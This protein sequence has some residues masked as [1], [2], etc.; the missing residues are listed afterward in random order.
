MSLSLLRRKLNPEYAPKIA[1]LEPDSAVFRIQIVDSRLNVGGQNVP[2]ASQAERLEQN[3]LDIARSLV[4][5]SHD[6]WRANR[7]TGN[8][9]LQDGTD[10]PGRSIGGIAEAMAG[11]PQAHAVERKRLRDLRGLQLTSTDRLD[12]TL[13]EPQTKRLLK[14]SFEGHE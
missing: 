8:V 6:P 1:N 10:P 12:S 14:V 13:H 5:Q 11:A 9:V 3:R 4:W 2:M 7:R